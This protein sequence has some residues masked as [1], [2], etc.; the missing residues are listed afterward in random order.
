MKSKLDNE[1]NQEQDARNTPSQEAGSQAPEARED[2]GKSPEGNTL[3][4]SEVA[5]TDEEASPASSLDSAPEAI[6]GDEAQDVVAQFLSKGENNASKYLD[7]LAGL[8]SNQEGYG[9]AESTLLGIYD[10]IEKNGYIT[11]KQME[12]V[13]NIKN[14]DNTT[15]RKKRRSR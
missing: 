2:S 5:N 12:S 15:N 8:L 7:I 14:Y 4:E 3:F 9:W 13:D 10:F 11:E 6:G 1:K